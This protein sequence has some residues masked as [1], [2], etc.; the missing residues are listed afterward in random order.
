MKRLSNYVVVSIAACAL[1]FACAPRGEP[2]AAH[3][4]PAGDEIT[5]E[6]YFEDVTAASGVN[7]TY[8]NG[9]E[10]GHLALLEAMGGGVGMIDYD[11]DGLLDLFFTGGGYFDGPNKTDIKGHPCKLYRNRGGW[12][13]EDVTAAAGLDRLT[14]GQ[15]WFYTHGVAVADYDNDGW[16]DLLVTGWG[17]LALFHNVSGESGGR[18]F[19]EVTRDAGLTDSL[20]SLSAG[21]GDLDADGFPDLYVVHYVDW[22]FQNHPVCPGYVP[23]TPRAVCSPK[24]FQALPDTLYR[25][26]GNGKFVDASAQFGLRKD[27]KGLGVLI[28]DLDEDARPDVY[29]ANDTS[30]NFLYLNRG[31]RF[32][33]AAFPRGVA[34]SSQGKE[35]GSMGVDAADHDGTGRFS[36]F[37]T[38]YQLEAHALYR[39]LGRGQF[40]HVSDA[41]GI[42]AIGF[43]FVGFGT[44][45]LDFDR[46]GAEDIFIANGHITPHP[47][48]PSEQRQRPVLFRNLRKDA[49][50]APIVRF[51]DVSTRGGPF[52]RVKRIGRGAAFGDLD[53]DGRTDIAI[54]HQNEPAVL[55]RNAVDNGRHWL[56][57]EL[58][59]TPNRDAVGAVVTLE[60][61]NE[62]LVRQIK[63][64]GSYL[65]SNDRRVLFG[66]GMAK[67]APRLTVRWTSG[68]TQT[69]ENLAVDRYWKLTEGEPAAAESKRPSP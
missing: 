35:Q 62:K 53:N 12:R 2:P 42:S 31:G 18:R 48:P 49:P 6:A 23:H 45:F 26:L 41:A 44:G 22:S 14:D 52:F 15:P 17:R 27:G 21:W 60:T 57:A 7:A 63:G 38:N 59:G 29:V 8:R 25:N 54:S 61:G 43:T 20:W 69:W 37:V 34:Y 40:R 56:G 13:F 30:G 55:L 10:A 28:A 9:E 3:L 39:N 58:V 66:L 19:R 11:R 1:P 50:T 16:Q 67:D 33:E 51:E 24:A 36:L 64:G 4:E 32:E 68:K 46:D 47:Q 65:S 5:R